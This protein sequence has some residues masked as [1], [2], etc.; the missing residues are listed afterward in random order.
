MSD[1]IMRKTLFIIALLSVV[2]MFAYA[3]T[4]SQPTRLD[5]PTIQSQQLVKSGS[6]YNGTVYE[7]FSTAV[8]SERTGIGASYSPAQAPGGPKRDKIDGGDTK[9]SSQSPI[10]DAVLPLMAMLMVYGVW[11]MVHRR[12]CRKEA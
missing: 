4:F 1:G 11:C 5:N 3:Q 10:G 12:R 9:T 2:T 6:G 7:P 8:P